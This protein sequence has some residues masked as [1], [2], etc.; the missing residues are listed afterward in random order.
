MKKIFSVLTL[1]AA[2]T[3]LCCPSV[4]AAEIMHS[5]ELGAGISLV[6]TIPFVGMLLCIAICPLVI[7]EKWEKWR[8]LFVLFWSLLFLIP[9]ALTYNVPTMVDQ[10]LESLVGDY[11]TFIVLLFGLFCVAGNI[12]LEGDLAGTPK[13]NV[14]L[15]LIG[16]ALASWIGTTGASMVMIRPILRANRWRSKCVQTVVFFIFLVSNIGGCLT[17]IGDP[18]LL[19]GFMRGVP[20]TWELQ[21]LLPIMA[22]NVVL[23]LAIYF[24]MDQRAYRKDLAAGR[25]PLNGG[26]KLRLSGAH[27]IVFMLVIVLAVVLSGVLPGMPLFQNAAG[28]VLGIHIFGS[29]SLSYPTLIEIVMI[30]AAAFL[31][32]KTTKKDVRTKNNFTW[33]AI[34]EVAVLFIGI[35]ITMIP[36]LLFLKAHGADLGLTEPWQMFWATGALSSFLD[37]TPTYLVFMTTAGALGA[38]EGV[39]TTVGT[40]AVPMLIAISCGAVFMG[41]NTYIGNAPNFMVKSIAD[42]NGVKMPSFF[43]YMAWSVGILIPV[44]LIDTLLF[45]L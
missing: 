42:E 38:A 21:H 28:D 35:F 45:F 33:G 13:T 11:L 5:A 23:L 6:F 32:F 41:A 25:K 12:C 7:P 29:V 10:L 4:F 34:E 30:L 36:A 24:V 43:G 18:P 27:N 15:L 44:F 19:M 26:A 31:S 16:T 20:F 1:T 37:N 14:L 22:L 9:F 39:V 17:P 8:W 40:I 3:A 2:A